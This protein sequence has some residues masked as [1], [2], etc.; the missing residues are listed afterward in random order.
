MGDTLTKLSSGD[1]FINFTEATIRRQKL[2]DNAATKQSKAD[3]DRYLFIISH[4]IYFFYSLIL[5]GCC[6]N[7][8]AEAVT[9]E[10]KNEERT[11]A[12]MT[13]VMPMFSFLTLEQAVMALEMKNDNATEVIDWYRYHSQHTHMIHCIPLYDMTDMSH[14]T[15]PILWN[16]RMLSTEES[17][18]KFLLTKHVPHRRVEPRSTSRSGGTAENKTIRSHNDD[19]DIEVDVDE[20]E[21][22]AKGA[23][24]SS[25]PAG[26]RHR[27][28]PLY[29]NYHIIVRVLG[30]K[31]EGMQSLQVDLL[32][33]LDRNGLAMNPATGRAL[34]VQIPIGVLWSQLKPRILNDEESRSVMVDYRERYSENTLLLD[35]I[36]L[37]LQIAQANICGCYQ[38][39]VAHLK[40]EAYED[41]W[42]VVSVTPEV[43]LKQ[44]TFDYDSG[45]KKITNMSHINDGPLLFTCALIEPPSDNDD[46]DEDDAIANELMPPIA[47]MVIYS[48]FLD[49]QNYSI[50]HWHI[51]GVQARQL[52]ERVDIA[53]DTR[54]LAGNKYSLGDCCDWPLDADK[55]KVDYRFVV[56]DRRVHDP[57]FHI[58]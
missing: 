12:A 58:K 44:Y 14:N 5:S 3:A 9:R 4:F 25:L 38:N 32:G 22:D 35:L 57:T 37:L 36:F 40:F 53:I 55:R 13:S 27:V 7:S 29:R 52:S 34:R 51:R 47:P 1:N 30:I 31:G 2:S 42:A 18:V 8:A 56:K 43:D 54:H 6:A 33:V 50:L 45:A 41:S 17:E 28:T 19:D 46:E 20:D 24:P 10:K 39:R 49:D 21:T 26:Y 48:H 11:T 16:D 23:T 15:M